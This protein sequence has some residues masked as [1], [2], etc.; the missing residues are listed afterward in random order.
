VESAKANPF[1]KRAAL[2]KQG[3]LTDGATDDD[4]EITFSYYNY[5][6]V[7]KLFPVHP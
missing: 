7:D 3:L 4:V 5:D 1:N 2:Q 6:N